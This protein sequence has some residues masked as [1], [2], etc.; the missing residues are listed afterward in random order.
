MDV[1]PAAASRRAAPGTDASI[2]RHRGQSSP[3]SRVESGVVPT[4][5][6]KA[7]R[8]LGGRGV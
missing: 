1:Y 4:D 7:A 5:G 6:R 3:R 2:A 8:L